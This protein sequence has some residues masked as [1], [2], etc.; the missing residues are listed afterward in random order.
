M[1]EASTPD[2]VAAQAQSRGDG[3]PSGTPSGDAKSVGANLH[4]TYERG[5]GVA[6]VAHAPYQRQRNDPLYRKLRI[7]S[8]DPSTPRLEGAVALVDVPF[9]PLEPGPVGRLFKVDDY[10]PDQG[11]R[12]RPA[13]LDDPM[14]LIRSGYEP[15][16]SDPRFHQQMVYAVCSNVYAAF[17]AALGRQIGWRPGL[18]KLVLRP[19]AGVMENAYYDASAGSIEFGYYPAREGTQST[20][21]GGFVFACLS[22]DIIAHEVTH[23]LLDGLRAEFSRPSGPDVIAFHEAFADL[24]AIFQ[25]FSYR[26]VV[27]NAIRRTKGDIT[28]AGYLT[29]L[30]RQFGNTTGKRAALRDALGISA[31]GGLPKQYCDALEAHDLGSVLVSAVFDAF[32]KIYQR[33][34]ERYLRLA[35][36]GTGVLPEGEIPHELQT[37]LA[38]VVAKLASQFLSI[39]IRAIDYC[40]PVGLTFGDYLRALITADFDLVPDDPWDYRGAL[41]E[42]FRRRNIYPRHAASLSE[43]ALL[44]RGTRLELPPIDGLSFARLKFHGDPACVAD[45]EELRRQADVLGEFVTRSE[46]LHEFG[47]VSADDPRLEGDE[48]S[49]PRIESIRSARR[50]GPDGQIIFDLVAEVT[51]SRTVRARASCP[52]FAYH[53]GATIILDPHGQ[54]RYV[55][56]KSLLGA[57]RLERRCEFLLGQMGQH[58]WEV[59]GGAYVPRRQLFGLL[60]SEQEDSGVEGG[61]ERN[62]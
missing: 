53:G 38:E 12:Y 32:A 35:T 40:P 3:S 60:H 1:S 23:A 52:T 48:V 44:W 18:D 33:K 13:D 58:Y 19:H 2:A 45:D 49:L 56:L 27:Q 36:H 30:A 8:V 55:V 22:H 10:D 43:D 47:L 62:T 50:T 9:E 26:E 29:E 61:Q 46:Y 5:D 54:V 51:Q 28:R 16:Q 21:P 39:C 34:T 41:I 14:V 42:A 11:T 20:L 57:E 24:I 17:R 7:Y 25:R 6:R 31:E 4:R 15:S 59:S 37:L